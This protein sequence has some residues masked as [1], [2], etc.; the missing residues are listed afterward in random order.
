MIEYRLTKYNP[1]LRDARG[2]YTADDWTSI[3]DVGREFGGKV[4]TEDEYR[5]V[6]QTYI[7]SALTFLSEGGLTSLRVEGLENHKGLALEFGDGS[8]FSLG[9][10]G[11][12]IRQILREELWCRLEAQSG[13][14]HFGWDYYM[15][16]GVPRQCP[17]AERRVRTLGLYL[18]DFVSPYHEEP[19]K[20]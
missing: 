8:V 5:R 3:N 13:F 1:T 20:P 17:V 10:A 15:Y 16:I 12:V 2:A 18:E 14:V 11:N 9:E 7:D 4:L 6:E 19:S